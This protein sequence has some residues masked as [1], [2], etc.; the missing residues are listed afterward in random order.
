M[1]PRAVRGSRRA[2]DTTTRLDGDVPD[3][4]GSVQRPRRLV[5][6]IS[7]RSNTA[8]EGAGAPFETNN[9]VPMN[10]WCLCSGF[11]VVA[12]GPRPARRGD[13]DNFLTQNSHKQNEGERR[14][15]E[16]VVVGTR[17]LKRIILD[18]KQSREWRVC[19]LSRC[20][21]PSERKRGNSA[22]SGEAGDENPNDQ[23]PPLDNV[24]SLHSI[25]EKTSRFRKWHHLS[26]VGGVIDNGPRTTA[27]TKENTTLAPTQLLMARTP[28]FRNNGEHHASAGKPSRGSVA[29][30]NF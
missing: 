27:A 3:I 20:C 1:T 9:T 22:V 14:V 17:Q 4:L 21:H 30:K 15:S 6:T 8:S 11:V 29:R 5:E 7:R 28:S 25:A 2:E 19:S 24:P 16:G 12:E 26:T 18:P 23:T 13:P 10:S